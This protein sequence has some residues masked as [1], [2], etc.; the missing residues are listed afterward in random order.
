MQDNSIKSTCSY[1]GV[2]CGLLIKKDS[3]NKV[4]VEGDPDHPV[5]KGM[6]CSKGRNLHYV[7]NDTSDR[8]FY[9]QM[10]WSKSH[11]NLDRVDWDTALERAAHVFKSIIKQHGPD[12]VG[13]YV[14]GQCLTEEYYIANKLVKGFL[15]TNN[16]DTNS[17]LCMSSAVVGY[18]KTFGED[19]V[20]IS[21]ADIEL[22]DCFL[23]T[24]AN[25]AY[26]H[27]ILF[28]RIE[29]HKEKN[30]DVKII[31]V[32]PRRTDTAAYADLHLQ[33]L[34]GT[35]IILYNAIGRR[36]L[37]QGLVDKDFID[38]HTEGFTQYRAQVMQ[39]SL[40]EAAKQCGVPV[41]DIKKAAD[42]IGISKGFISMWA[43]GL[44]QSVVGTNK[45]FALLNLSLI[46]GQVGKPGSGPFSLTGQPNAMG[47][48]EVGGM[49]NLLA[50]HKDLM[51]ENHR[52]EVAHFWGVNE[53]SGKPGYTATQMFEALET[54]RLKAV[55]I[56]CTNPSVSLPDVRKVDKALQNAKFVVVQDISKRSDTLQ[57]ADLILPAAGWLEKEGTMTNSERRIS[58]LPKVVEA[59]GEARPDVEILCDFAQK[60]GFR[61]FDY[62]NTSEI[63]QEYAA[64]TKGT[65]I[66]ISYLNYDRL[67]NEGTFQWP[68]NTYR[69]TGTPRLFEDKKFYTP[70]KKAV[71]NIPSTLY[72][73]SIKPD[74]E[75]PFVLTTG[76][77]R[78]Q[79][80]TMT[81]TGKVSRLN[82]HYP[83]PVLEIHPVDAVKL[84]IREG[85]ICEVASENGNVRVKAK[86]TDTIRQGVV[87]LPMHWGKKL[88]SDLNRTN[89]LTQNMVDPQSKEP[90]FKFTAVRVEKYTKKREKIVVIGSG[91]AA[92]RFIQNYR[93]RNTQDIICVFSKEA[94]PFYNRVLLPEYITEELSWEQLLKIKEQHL[95]TL[96]IRLFKN[97]SIVD[98]DKKSRTLKDSQGIYHAYDKLIVATGSRAF[99]PTDVRLDLPGRFTMRDK[100]DADRFKKYLIQSGIPND[101]QHVVIVGGGLLG[102]ELAAALRH[103]SVKITIIQRSSYLME[104]QLDSIA[105]NMLANNVQQRGIQIYFD[106]EVST[107]FDAEESHSLE[108]TLK[109]GKVLEANAIVYAVGTRP[110]IEIARKAGLKMGKGLRVNEYMQ[111]SD[112][113]IFALGEIAEFRNQTF[114]ITAA[115]EEQANI[116]ANYLAGDISNPYKGSVLMNILKFEDLDLCSIGQVSVPKNDPSYEEVIFMDVSKQYYKK[117]IIKDDLLVGA[118]LMGDKQEFAEF[119]NLIDSRIELA[120]K[121]ELLLRGATKQEPVK[122][123]LIC[124]CSQVGSGNIE[125]AIRQGCTDFTALCDQ[126]GAGLGCGSCKTEVRE[127]LTEAT[128]KL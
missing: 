109:S 29:A 8:L 118:I 74:A 87:F 52:R 63:Y 14:S 47:G 120:E 83:T 73:R 77:V 19:S 115:A 114:G 46:T 76:R 68:V 66:D 61:G 112:A 128:V 48:R 103:K 111:T 123:K 58:H 23:I 79:W 96:D 13:F 56:I 65:N 99:V 43:M 90:D 17:R 27:P 49:A 121:R 41:A 98:I 45:N 2:G 104:R 117:C 71:F 94:H 95:S 67:K 75:Y 9:P 119:K 10:R 88:A 54:G 57:Y 110:N 122:G 35:D 85:T 100:L 70:S 92:F 6:L 53:I 30:P 127:L 101:Q 3:K 82:T 36:L 15:G 102:L 116:L 38:N 24:G 50:V 28:R 78:D 26:C 11:P 34:P 72:N 106:N 4:S 107:V 84:K 97:N 81:K 125:E 25:P 5:N 86:L 42:I 80:H 93:E 44:N 21:Y 59:P 33:L 16:I 126:T 60:M 51:N 18:K 1:C 124:S 69:H 105:S 40:K 39:L 32:D 62:Y 37:E 20:P 108:V 31:A 91:A 12:S 55:W 113:S 89:N 22:A 7:V 64:M